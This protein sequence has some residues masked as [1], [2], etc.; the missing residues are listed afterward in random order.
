MGDN[1]YL[2]DRNGV[3]T[4]MQWS[5]DRNAGF[6]RANPQRLYLPVNID[7]EYHYEAINVETQQNNPNSLFWWM[8]RVVALRKQLRPMG[9]GSLEFLF[10][11][12]R[13]VLAFIRRYE[14]ERVLVVANLSRFTQCVELDLSQYQGMRPVEVFGSTEF[15]PVTDRLYFLSLAPHAFHWFTLEPKEQEVGLRIRTGEPPTLVVESWENVFSPAVRAILNPMLP[16]FLRGRRWY[17]GRNRTI[18]VAQIDEVIPFPKSRSYLLLLRVD[19]TE[20]DPDFYTL[21]LSVGTDHVDHPEFILARLRGPDGTGLLYSGLRSRDFCDELLGA[22][23]RRRR[24]AGEEGELLAAHTRAFRGLWGADRPPLEPT[25][26]RADQDNST[27]F[28]GDRFALKLLRK[29]EEGP[30]P[31]EE[32]GA[33]LTKDGLPSVAPLAGTIEYRTA[34]GEPMTIAVLH[35]YRREAVDFWQYTLD[36]PGIFYENAL[37]RGPA[38]PSADPA[39]NDLGRELITS[40]LELVR[41]LGIRTGEMHA[42]LASHPND[43]VFAPEPFTDFY[44]H[45]LH[46]GMLGRLSRT[47]DQL[48]TALSRLP[49]AV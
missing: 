1:I 41:L 10:P 30:H 45:G 25:V 22:I 28:Y 35:G 38:G 23:L 7:P 6:S 32:I 37:A 12:N 48:R 18:R 27:L 14:E 29:V 2:G 3:R 21:A 49:E 42:A 46:H 11:E 43:P 34:E 36:H 39:S 24:Y 31:E 9:R 4:P 15:P 44:R 20:G 33:L 8:K 16:S 17:R 40:Y 19:F 47:S 13:R 5:G 26:A